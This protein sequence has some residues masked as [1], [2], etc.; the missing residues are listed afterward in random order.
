MKTQTW[1]H[2]IGKSYYTINAFIKEAERIGISRAIAPA[3]LRKMNIGDIVMLAQRDG[4]STKVFGY[5]ITKNITGLTPDTIRSMKEYSIVKRISTLVPMKIQR[6]CG[7]YEITASYE[8][9]DTTLAME[10]I[11]TLSDDKIGRVMIG[12]EFYNLSGL[13]I[14]SDYVLTN[15]PFRKG[16]RLFNLVDFTNEFSMAY[17]PNTKHVKL[18]GQ[19]Y[20][21]SDDKVNVN[22]EVEDPS[23]F[24]IRNY[25][26]N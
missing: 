15:I 14:P 22:Y 6:G 17:K 10:F 25:Q 9:T 11:H 16:Y 1:I 3:V 7:E 20:A 5:F 21:T 24:E 4:A 18:R 12:G 19:F 23:L 8:I 13:G 26:L 2:F